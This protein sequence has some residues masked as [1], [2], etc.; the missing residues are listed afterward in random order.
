MCGAAT[1]GGCDGRAKRTRRHDPLLAGIGI[2]FGIVALAIVLLTWVIHW[3]VE[4]PVAPVEREQLFAADRAPVV[5]PRPQVSAAR[6]LEVYGPREQH[7]SARW[8]CRC[9]FLSNCASSSK[10]TRYVVSPSAGAV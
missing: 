3:G 9:K 8:M 5:G 6:G 2:V 1:T 7:M 4:Y 10:Q